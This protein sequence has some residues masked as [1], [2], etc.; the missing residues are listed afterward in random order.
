MKQIIKQLLAVA[1]LLLATLSTWA[2]D[3]EDGGIYYGKNSDGKTVY[4]TSGGNYYT[5]SVVIPSKVYYGGR[6]YSVTM[7][8]YEAFRGC[9]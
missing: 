8:G 6:T 9:S 5:G 2:Y 4:V 3:F 1:I 7:I